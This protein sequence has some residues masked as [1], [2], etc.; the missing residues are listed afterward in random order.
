M[1]NRRAS[2]CIELSVSRLHKIISKTIENML[3]GVLREVISKN[4]FTFIKGRQLLDYSLITNEVIDLL[5]KDHDEGL[6]FKIDFE[7]AFNSVE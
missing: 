1:N 2:I 7:K 5:R 4:Q 3:K 6:S